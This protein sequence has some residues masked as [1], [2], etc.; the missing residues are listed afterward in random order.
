ML[1]E[2]WEMEDLKVFRKADMDRQ[3]TNFLE[4][5]DSVQYGKFKLALVEEGGDLQRLQL[6]LLRETAES[7]IRAPESASA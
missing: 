1:Q 2:E 3:L 7:G 5:I 6:R 4:G